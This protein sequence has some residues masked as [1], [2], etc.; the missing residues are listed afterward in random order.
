VTQ[1]NLTTE[2]TE[3]FAEIT[4]SLRVLCAFSVPSVVDLMAVPPRNTKEK[5][6]KL[7][8]LLSNKLWGGVGAAA[9]AAAPLFTQDPTILAFVGVLVGGV[10][11][12]VEKLKDIRDAYATIGT[13]RPKA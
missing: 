12:V 1:K 5:T 13:K 3:V 2:C 6:M 7:N 11:V 8:D 4:E 9:A 10:T